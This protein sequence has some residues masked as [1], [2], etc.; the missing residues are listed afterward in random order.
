M[1]T[2]L[3]PKTDTTEVTL[4]EGKY[5]IGDLCYVFDDN[6]W[7]EVCS[8]T[9]GSD[10]PLQ[11]KYKLADGREFVMF[12]TFIGDGVYDI[13]YNGQGVS[14]APV[15][16]GTIGAILAKDVNKAI[17]VNGR[18]PYFITDLEEGAVCS[19][20]DDGTMTFG[21]YEIHTGY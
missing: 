19:V 13:E 17:F 14:Y 6:E 4:P 11:G 18:S 21:D 2:L 16:S 8:L 20:D 3:E 5:Y 12:R 15:D 7:D 1:D 10:R 9:F